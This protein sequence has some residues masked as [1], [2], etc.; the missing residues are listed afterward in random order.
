VARALMEGWQWLDNH[1]FVAP[2]PGEDRRF[3]ESFLTRQ[4]RRVAAQRGGLVEF[5]RTVA[6]RRE[7]LHSILA[8]KV[9]PTYIR[10]DLETAVF[11]SFK[12]V[13]ISVR[14][15]GEFC[16]SAYGVELMREAFRPSN[17]RL[18]D[19]EATAAEREAASAL[20][21]GALGMFKNPASHREV[22]F[23]D[24]SVAAET[25]AFASL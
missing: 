22:S 3:C 4:A 2:E 19:Q 17:G 14:G 12:Q 13:E 5:L 18:A 15:V 9:W 25:I 6:L 23:D 20:F 8:E 16:A 21:A 11:Q 7:A 24:P 10:G 1:G